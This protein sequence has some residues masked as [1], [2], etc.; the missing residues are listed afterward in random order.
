V[1]VLDGPNTGATV[2]AD[3]NGAYRFDSLNFTTMN[4]VARASG[5]LDDS[6]G[7]F[8]NGTNMLNFVLAVL[9][10]PPPVAASITITSRVISGAVPP[11]QEWGFTATGT[12][13]FIAYDWDFGDGGTSG[14]S[15]ADE[16]HVYRSKGMFTVTVTGRRSSGSPIVATTVIEVK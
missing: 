3:G 14:D 6:R 16:Q 10:P 5:Y 9:P 1:T 4:F 2:L 8:V 12:V 13:P 15:R 7:T 11:G